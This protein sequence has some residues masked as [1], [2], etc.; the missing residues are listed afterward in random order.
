MVVLSLKIGI[1]VAA[2]G[3][4]LCFLSSLTIGLDQPFH[5]R[6]DVE[7]FIQ[8]IKLHWLLQ[9]LIR[10]KLLDAVD[11]SFDRDSLRRLLLFFTEEFFP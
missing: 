2:L 3:L 6:V 10:Y 8:W 7:S 4:E 11:L 1:V 9:A 5:D